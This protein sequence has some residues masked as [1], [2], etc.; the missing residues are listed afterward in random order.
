MRLRQVAEMMRISEYD[1]FRRAYRECHDGAINDAVVARV[2]M[3]YT[4]D[5]IVPVWVSTFA[6][7]IVETC[8]VYVPLRSVA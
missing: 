4:R 5:G 2:F 6:R 7:N 8:K 3:R 1:L